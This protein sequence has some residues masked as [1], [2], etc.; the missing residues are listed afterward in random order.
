MFHS[1]LNVVWVDFRA[2]LYT[3]K[4]MIKVEVKIFLMVIHTFQGI[5]TCLKSEE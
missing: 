1:V 3:E 2:A 5:Q 4:I